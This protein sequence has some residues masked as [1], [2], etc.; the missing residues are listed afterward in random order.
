MTALD[1]RT[2]VDPQLLTGSWDI[3]PTHTEVAFTIRHLMVSKVRGRF[4]SFSGSF[5]IAEDP[6]A[7]RVETTVD[8]ASID[9]NHSDRDAHVRSADFFDVERYPAMTYRSTAVRPDGDRWVVDGE[10]TLH[11]VTRPV[12]LAL[13]VVGFVPTTP[14]GD[15]RVGFSATAE[16]DR[17]DFG[18]EWNA[19]VEGGGVVLGHKVQ[20][21][22][23]IE[24]IRRAD[25]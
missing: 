7:S 13:E 22:L 3:D 17:R 14:F 18:L 12:P 11:G 1:T 9:T 15:S 21:A 19:P 10:L 8:L 6:A 2:G 23:E 4:S 20:I 25:A 5:E 24:A 16:I